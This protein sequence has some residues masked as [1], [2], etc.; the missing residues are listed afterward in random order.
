MFVVY[1]SQIRMMSGQVCIL[2]LNTYLV[3]DIRGVVTVPWLALH[4][5]PWWSSVQISARMRDCWQVL[6]PCT[7]P[8]PRI[9]ETFLFVPQG[10]W[11]S[12]RWYRYQAR[13]PKLWVSPLHGFSKFHSFFFLHDF[14]PVLVLLHHRS[15]YLCKLL[16]FDCLIQRALPFLSTFSTY[17]RKCEK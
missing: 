8:K 9:R 6:C 14:I 4:L 13:E 1:S 12:E 11:G 5:A 16:S 3:N 2:M 10:G 7:C 17:C 15:N